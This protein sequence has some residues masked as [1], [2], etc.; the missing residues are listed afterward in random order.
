MSMEV[1]VFKAVAGS[2]LQAV[3]CRAIGRMPGPHGILHLPKTL[4]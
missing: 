3:L 4:M 1:D 2:S